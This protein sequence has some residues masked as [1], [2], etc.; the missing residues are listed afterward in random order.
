[1]SKSKIIGISVASAA[2]V[3]AVGTILF[4]WLNGRDV[5]RVLA[6]Q[7]AGSAESADFKSEVMNVANAPGVE[8]FP[9]ELAK[10]LKI[11]F[12]KRSKNVHRYCNYCCNCRAGWIFYATRSCI[13]KR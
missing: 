12:F 5:R 3:A 8:I 4:F 2:V 13:N 10:G 9:G 6:M 1:M 11:L 7:A